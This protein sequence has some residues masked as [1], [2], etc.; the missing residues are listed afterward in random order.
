MHQHEVKRNLELGDAA[1][2]VGVTAR[3][4]RGQ[5]FLDLPQIQTP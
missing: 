3:V 2:A 5:L 4:Q 1:P